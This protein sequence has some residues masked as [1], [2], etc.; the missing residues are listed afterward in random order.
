MTNT[1]RYQQL[2][3]F[4]QEH[5]VPCSS[6]DPCDCGCQCANSLVPLNGDASFRRYYR[7]RLEPEQCEALCRKEHTYP[8]LPER[9]RSTVIAVDAPP[10][11]QKNR[12][13]FA[14]NRLLSHAKVLVSAILC[15]DLEH[16]FMVQEDLGDSLF[17][18]V[19]AD[20]DERLGF[21][22]RALVELNKISSLPLNFDAMEALTTA[23][24]QAQE[25]H[26]QGGPDDAVLIARYELDSDDFAYLAQLPP[27]D[28]AFIRMELGIFTQWCLQE[29]LHLEL[30]AAEQDMLERSFSFLSEACRSQ[31]QVAMHRDFHSRNIMITPE[32]CRYCIQAQLALLDYQDMLVGPI[33]YDC[34]SLLY[35][36]YYVLASD[37]REMLLA[38]LFKT[39]QV[40]GLLEARCTL[41]DFKQMVLV[42][43]IQRH[44]KVLGIFNRL[45]LRDG[46]EGYLQYLPQVVRYLQENCAQVKAMQD[47]LAFLESRVAP[48]LLQGA[49]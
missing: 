26:A 6:C 36:C 20:D 15:A 12:E 7:V 11:T 16:G 24:Q 27:F 31:K 22:F 30:S 48:A 21:Y 1:S 35:D 39:Y 49:K 42:C 4:L 8:H 18:D 10:E 3:S 17:Y 37:E 14:I 25:R 5:G 9:Y 40:S 43:A 33:G 44:I 46:K 23:R 13:F 34:A 47:F 45:H 19:L 28:D 2:L 32:G 29:A 41:E 38:Q